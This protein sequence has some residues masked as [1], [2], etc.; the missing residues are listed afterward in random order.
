[1]VLDALREHSPESGYT[2]AVREAMRKLDDRASRLDA[3]KALS[4]LAHPKALGDIYLEG[5]PGFEWPNLVGGLSLAAGTYVR[6]FDP[7][8]PTGRVLGFS[9][10]ELK[11]LTKAS[12]PTYLHDPPN[13]Q[14]SPFRK[15]WSSKLVFIAKFILTPL[16]V[17]CIILLLID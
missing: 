11:M 13:I 12:L 8:A 9:Q 16:A 1:M 10:D 17:V 2:T 3:V 5:M 15:D 14:K 4:G 6:K 7:N